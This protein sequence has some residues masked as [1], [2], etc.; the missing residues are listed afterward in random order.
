MKQDKIVKS[1]RWIKRVTAATAVVVWIVVI[2]EI[3]GSPAPFAEEAPYCLFSTMAIFG[4]LSMIFKGLEYWER[5]AKGE[6]EERS[7]P[8][9]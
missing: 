1:I 5:Q 3:A 4:V 9:S 6:K 2:Y 7:G 8:A